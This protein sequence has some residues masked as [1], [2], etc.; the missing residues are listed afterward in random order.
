MQRVLMGIKHIRV[1]LGRVLK[2]LVMVGVH[3]QRS[4]NGELIVRVG[5]I[6]RVASV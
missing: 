6:G 5:H 1:E 3:G 4:D 2:R